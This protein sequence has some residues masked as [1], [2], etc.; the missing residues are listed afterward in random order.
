MKKLIHFQ[1]NNESFIFQYHVI[2]QNPF[3]NGFTYTITIY[4]YMKIKFNKRETSL[5][6]YEMTER[7]S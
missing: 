2:I 4:I 5:A 7:L 1:Y 6:Q 3:N